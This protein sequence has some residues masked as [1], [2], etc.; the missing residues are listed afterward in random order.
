MADYTLCGVIHCTLPCVHTLYSALCPYIVLC[1]V[2]IHC[3]LPCVHTL[4]SALCPYI[5][6]C[7][8]S[9]HCIE[10]VGYVCSLLDK[11]LFL[12]YTNLRTRY[13]LS[14][15]YNNSIILFFFCTIFIGHCI[16]FLIQFVSYMKSKTCLV[17]HINL[18]TAV[19]WLYPNRVKLMC[20]VYWAL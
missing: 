12:G 8:V 19:Y 14:Y 5:V 17:F 15:F 6:L 10:T 18:Y 4:Y 3:T 13:S 11:Q 20:I 9:I 2:S 16:L 7:P 1:P